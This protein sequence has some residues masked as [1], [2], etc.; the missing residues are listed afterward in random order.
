MGHSHDHGSGHSH[1]P[2][3]F[4]KA[5]AIGIALN[6]GFVVVEAA[7]GFLSNSTALLADAGHNLSD[8][9]GLLVAW[10]AAS[11]ARRAPAGRFTYGLRGSSILAA[12]FNA[13]FLLVS[14][15]AIG[16][17]SI[18]RLINPEPVAGLTVMIVAGIGIVINGATA[19][20]FASGR[21]AD[22]NIEG[23]YLHMAADAAVSLGVVIAAGVILWTGW[24]WVDPAMSLVICLAILWSTYGLLRSS[25]S[26]SLNA[27]PPGVDVVAVRAFL[28]GLPGVT[29]VHDLHIWPIST[30]ETALTCHVVIPSGHPGDR[31]LVD[32]AH[33]LVHDFGIG[34]TTIQIEVSEDTPCALAPDE[35]V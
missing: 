35:V 22:I 29:Q 18:L 3:D 7:F 10:G 32:A 17:E 2:A 13:I 9:L 31:F 15:G 34:H 33:E 14:V 19:L 8:V 30:T 12:L 21:K 23:A 1:A 26:M 5:F 25:V 24:T 27:V 20:M 6:T 11:L 28:R 16:W 4:G